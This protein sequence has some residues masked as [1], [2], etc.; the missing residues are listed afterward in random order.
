MARTAL[1]EGSLVGISALLVACSQPVAST[2]PTVDTTSTTPTPT[3]PS[4]ASFV[5]PAPR[6]LRLVEVPQV[7]CKE[8]VLD[9]STIPD[10]WR[11]R[12]PNVEVLSR[13]DP[14]GLW[15][16]SSPRRVGMN[17]G[18]LVFE[19]AGFTN[20]PG[21]GMIV[22]EIEV[23]DPLARAAPETLVAAVE[24]ATA[25]WTP[26]PVR[27]LPRDEEARK[28]VHAINDICKDT[29][30]ESEFAFD[31]EDLACDEG[32]CALSF[33][34]LHML[35]RCIERGEITISRKAASDEKEFLAAVEPVLNN[36]MK[37][38]SW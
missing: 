25:T 15:T 11:H 2:T 12:R 17:E 26:P 30:C 21:R 37:G 19:L 9:E 7:E 24:Q 34:A 36:W 6:R 29:Y 13:T 38:H 8:R 1:R 32:R 14:S 31:F 16:L 4:A 20:E 5:E 22:Y 18:V 33:S 3:A 35:R 10:S 28:R 27:P 23:E